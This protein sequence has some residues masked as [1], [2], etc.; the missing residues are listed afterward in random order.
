MGKVSQACRESNAALLDFSINKVQRSRYSPA[1]AAGLGYYAE[2]KRRSSSRK[3][4][5]L[6]LPPPKE[7]FD[8]EGPVECETQTHQVTKRSSIP[9]K[10]IVASLASPTSLPP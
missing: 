9:M 3:S 4:F 6:P 2:R 5:P 8:V 10:G 1:T 7:K